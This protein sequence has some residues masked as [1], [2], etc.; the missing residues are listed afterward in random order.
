MFS[1]RCPHSETVISFTQ[2]DPSTLGLTSNGM[3]ALQ[4]FDDVDS[5]STPSVADFIRS[6][7]ASVRKECPQEQLTLTEPILAAFQSLVDRVLKGGQWS[8]S[9]ALTHLD[10]NMSNIVVT[11]SSK[12][13]LPVISGILDWEF[14]GILPR[15]LAASYPDWLRYDGY[16][17]PRFNPIGSATYYSWEETESAAEDL[18]RVFD[19]VNHSS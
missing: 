1:I 9:F 12:T 19:T 17:D 6:A 10:L 3:D 5:E 16:Y 14:H 8:D 7:I 13:T 2:S 11:Y 18:R 15:D 4:T